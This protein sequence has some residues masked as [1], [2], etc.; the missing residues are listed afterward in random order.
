[1]LKRLLLALLLLWL[2]GTSFPLNAQLSPKGTEQIARTL[3]DWSKRQKRFQS[4]R[5]V[6]VGETEQMDLPKD[7][8]L[9]TKRPIKYLVLLDMV[10]G[11]I[12]IEKDGSGVKYNYSG[13]SPIVDVRAYNG[14]IYQV[15]AD[16][17]KGEWDPRNANVGITKGSMQAVHLEADLWPVLFA[18]GIVP[19]VNKPSRPDRMLIGHHADEFE[20]RGEV[21]HQ[22]SRCF[23]LRTDPAASTPFL[24]DELFIDP[25]KESAVI[26][27]VNWAGKCP[28]YRVDVTYEEKKRGWLPRSWT[29]AHTQG[30]DV[31][32]VTRARVD[33]LEVNP[34]VTDDD[35]NLPIPPKSI[36][37]TSAYPEAGSG[38]DPFRPATKRSQVDERGKT[39]TVEETGFT[40]A[41]GVQLPP[42]PAF[43]RWLWIV[44][45]SIGLVGL[46][47]AVFFYRRRIRRSPVG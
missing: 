10:Q 35:F 47:L 21:S 43:P 25:G 31:V 14:R 7:S 22:G 44:A 4:V 26:R 34:T 19:T 46:L 1:M 18:H 23:I 9:P 16:R 40:T 15:N 13:Y 36:V 20:Y 17:T 42:E 5:Y 11:R 38:L 37:V 33:N 30:S 24:V 29:V 27:Y 3:N 32:Y 45:A 2:A 41:E 8:K 12:R 6:V 39:T 28:W